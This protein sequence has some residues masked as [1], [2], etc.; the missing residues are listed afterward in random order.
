MV[1]HFIFNFALLCASVC[2]IFLFTNDWYIDPCLQL[3]LD[4]GSSV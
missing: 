2:L 1:W 3:F 4:L